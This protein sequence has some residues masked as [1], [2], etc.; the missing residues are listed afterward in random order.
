MNYE[1]DYKLPEYV[2]VGATLRWYWNENNSN[3]KTVHIR[4]IVD[5]DQIVY[6]WW[7][8]R[9]GWQYKVE[10]GYWFWLLESEGRTTVV[11]RG[12]DAP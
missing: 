2:K 12:E 3:N 8:R 5:G 11:K 10:W 6:R 4:A 1:I 7:S 9:K